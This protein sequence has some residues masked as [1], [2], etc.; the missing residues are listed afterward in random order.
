MSRI[1]SDFDSALSMSCGEYAGS[2][3]RISG[4]KSRVELNQACGL[5]LSWDRTSG[6]Y[7]V[8]LSS[9]SSERERIALKPENLE[10]I[11]IEPTIH[12]VAAQAGLTLACSTSSA[13]A[14][15]FSDGDHLIQPAAAI[16]IRGG[17]RPRGCGAYALRTISPGERLLVETP[18]L[19]WSKQHGGQSLEE[20]V[21][22]LGIG[23]RRDYWSLCQSL[24]HGARRTAIGT[25]RSN[26]LPMYDAAGNAAAFRLLSR[27]N[28]C[29]KPNAHAAWNVTLQRATL[30]ALAPIDPGEEIVI[31][32]GGGGEGAT[33]E[34]RQA[35]LRR[36]FGF[37]CC[38]DLCSLD[39]DLAAESDRRQLELASLGRRLQSRP[40]DTLALVS[41]RLIL[42]AEEG[43]RTSW[44][45]YGSAMHFLGSRGDGKGAAQWGSR[46]AMCAAIALG[47]DSVVVRNF[48]QSFAGRE[49]EWIAAG[50]SLK[51]HGYVILDGF[52][53]AH[54]AGDLTAQLTALYRTARGTSEFR[55]GA[56]GGGPEGIGDDVR[57]NDSIRGDRRALIDVTD[58][59]AP[60]LHS[61]FFMVDQMLGMMARGAGVGEL[62]AITHRSR[63]MFTCYEGGAKYIR[64]IDNPDENGR[65]I[66]C[67]LYLNEGRKADDGGELV[68][69]PCPTGRTR[70][71]SASAGPPV[72]VEPLLD[73][74]VC[75]WSDER[76]P[77]E[78]LPA[79]SERLAV[80]VWYHNRLPSQ[81]RV[82]VGRLVEAEEE[83]RRCEAKWN[84]TTH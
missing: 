20:A 4:V 68:L 63:P 81:A 62:M 24:E 59:R 5:A 31:H 83:K 28:H 18:L 69:Y 15:Q 54:A 66:T 41:R 82:D 19:A 77:H 21:A 46:A 76:T 14:W 11:P 80:S 40:A 25:W 44:D 10:L 75:F 56:V 55:H 50:K 37:A 27:L 72:M 47:K 58:P 34:Q 6:R 48:T 36:A 42:M 74:L 61:A 33:R 45:T 52:C 67:I 22:R 35:A 70:K 60:G 49:E 13:T 1:H 84:R 2:R 3:V 79:K 39:P 26:A 29:C 51:E 7:A 38:C 53:G 71:G 8:E 65:L 43:I 64:H 23:A 30:H 57:N 12:E 16:G 17:S 78:V 32:Y 73:R 9:A